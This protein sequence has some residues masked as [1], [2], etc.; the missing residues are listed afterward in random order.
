MAVCR[1]TMQEPTYASSSK[2]SCTVGTLAWLV[3]LLLPPMLQ[4]L[5]KSGFG[6]FAPLLLDL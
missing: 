6:A 1:H 3:L 5:E 2:L 4:V